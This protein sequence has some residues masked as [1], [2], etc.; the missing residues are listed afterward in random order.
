MLKERPRCPVCSKLL[1]RARRKGIRVKKNDPYIY[2]RNI[3]CDLF[4]RD[5]TNKKR[6]PRNKKRVKEPP[7]IRSARKRVKKQLSDDASPYL[8]TITLVAQEMGHDDLANAIIDKY[9]LTGFY[10][11]LKRSK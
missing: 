2:C 10:G 7:T 9:D 6:K 8:L 1:Y 3:E 4:G 5:Q 11:V